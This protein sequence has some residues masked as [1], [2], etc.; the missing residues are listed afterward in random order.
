MRKNGLQR[1][2]PRMIVESRSEP[3]SA[4]SN[5]SFESVQTVGPGYA[6]AGIHRHTLQDGVTDATPF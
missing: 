2:F 6:E 4:V 5:H 1:A 3:E